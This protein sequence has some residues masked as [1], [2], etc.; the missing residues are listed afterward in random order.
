MS[1]IILVP[2]V[3]AQSN[4]RIFDSIRRI[5]DLFW[6]MVGAFFTPEILKTERGMLGF[7]K[8]TLFFLVFTVIHLGASKIPNIGNRRAIAIAMIFALIAIPNRAIIELGVSYMTFIVFI[9]AFGPLLAILYLTMSIE[10]T[11]GGRVIRIILIFIAIAFTLMLRNVV[12]NFIG[13]V[14]IIL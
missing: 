10:P 1:L 8:F 7:I 14:G 11:T 12:E 2:N 4:E 3:F 9:L 5:T 6:G 13:Y